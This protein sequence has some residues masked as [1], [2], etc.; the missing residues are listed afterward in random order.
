MLGDIRLRIG[1]E[2]DEELYN[3]EAETSDAVPKRRI[4]VMPIA[5]TVLRR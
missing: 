2:V 4:E 5:P 1:R 3:R